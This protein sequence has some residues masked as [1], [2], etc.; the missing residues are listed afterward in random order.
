MSHK[1]IIPWNNVIAG[2][3]H[4]NMVEQA[5]KLFDMI[6]GRDN[7]LWALMV[8]CYTRKGKL[9]KDLVSYNSMLAGYTQN[10]KLSLAMR[11]FVFFERM[12]ERNVVSWNLMVAGHEKILEAR[13][14][15]DR[16]PCKNVVSWNAVIATYVQVLQID[17]A[18]KLFKEMSYEDCVSW[19][20]I[21]NGYIQVHWQESLRGYVA[22]ILT[23]QRALIVSAALDLLAGTSTNLTRDFLHLDLSCG[24]G[25]PFFSLLLPYVVLVG[26]LNDRLLLASLTEINPRQKKG[27]EIKS[28]LV[29]L[30]EPILIGV[31]TMQRS[32]EQKLDLS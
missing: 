11:F 15:F 20:T 30:L 32:F 25:L 1:N 19:T 23:T 2:Y 4:N 18:V 28:C 12:I 3:L 31:A 17:E 29:G 24:V 22:G 16:M 14:L 8:T 26:A 7:F 5:N 6:P 21:I 13:K 27:V 10:R 9:V